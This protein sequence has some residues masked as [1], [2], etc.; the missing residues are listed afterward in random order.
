MSAIS[1]KNAMN[2]IMLLE[3][4]QE[5]KSRPVDTD[6]DDSIEYLLRTRG[7]SLSELKSRLVDLGED[8]SEID[9]LVIDPRGR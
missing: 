4:I 3:S 1:V 2:E 8:P 6:L 7:L 9:I 5:A